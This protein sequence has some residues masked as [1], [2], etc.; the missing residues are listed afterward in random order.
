MVVRYT[1]AFKR[2]L[3]RLSKKYRRI[4]LDVA[5]IILSLESGETPGDQ[6]Q[7]T[8]LTIY[9]IRARNTDAQSGKSGG[10]RIL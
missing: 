2:Q 9:K 7:G 8:G 4:R 3:K 10:Y 5:P 1:D 6:V